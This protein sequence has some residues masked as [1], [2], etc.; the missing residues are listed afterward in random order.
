MIHIRR[1][2]LPEGMQ[3]FGRREN[4]SVVLYVSAELSA[5]GRAAAIR[6][7]LHA[8]PEAGWRSPRSPVLLPALAGGAGL[9]LAPGSRW[10][11]RAL[12]AV[13]AAGVIAV[14]VMITATALGGGP[15]SRGPGS[16]PAALAPSPSASGPAHGAGGPGRAGPGTGAR[17]GPASGRPGPAARQGHGGKP[18]SSGSAPA[19]QTSGKPVPVPTSTT[20]TTSAP[21]P[22]PTRTPTPSPSTGSGGGSQQTCVIVLGVEIC[23]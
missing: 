7:A 8:A 18:G 4:G 23:V 10:T 21:S 17:S 11:Y 1:V 19:P 14:I 16:P 2:R 5:G 15:L 22:Q 13:V 12:F 20:T 6:R 3:V 9:P